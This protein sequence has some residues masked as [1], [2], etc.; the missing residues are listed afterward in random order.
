MNDVSLEDCLN[1]D[2]PNCF[3]ARESNNCSPGKGLIALCHAAADNQEVQHFLENIRNLNASRAMELTVRGRRTFSDATYAPVVEVL[4]SLHI[5]DYDDFKMSM[6][7]SLGSPT[8]THIGLRNCTKVV[9][10]RNDLWFFSRLAKLELVDSAVARIED[11]AFNLLPLLGQLS[12][13][14]RIPLIKKMTSVQKEHLRL[15]HCDCQYKWLRVYFEQ[16]PHLIAEKRSGEVFDLGGIQSA[17]VNIRDVYAPI[18]CNK[19]SLIGETSQTL[20][21]VNDPC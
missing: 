8:I 7:R 5:E 16:N 2:T 12:L 13:D 11:G 20:F 15:L 1:V 3:I 6:I 9:I 19:N 18:D 21:S 4:V 14:G 10:R 17:A